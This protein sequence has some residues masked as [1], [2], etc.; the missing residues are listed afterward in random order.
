MCE[1]RGRTIRNPNESNQQKAE[2]RRL[3]SHA[4]SARKENRF[5]DPKLEH[6]YAGA[7]RNA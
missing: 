4:P 1:P 5:T 2:R 6:P 3:H 7:S